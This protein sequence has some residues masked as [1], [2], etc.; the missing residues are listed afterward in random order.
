MNNDTKSEAEKGYHSQG[1]SDAIP[2]CPDN[3]HCKLET[4]DE[5]G[6]TISNLNQRFEAN[7]KTIVVATPEEV[8]QEASIGN[9]MA[10]VSAILKA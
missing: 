6:F 8:Q 3:F 4:H 2:G 7:S 1:I 9:G 10:I 5:N